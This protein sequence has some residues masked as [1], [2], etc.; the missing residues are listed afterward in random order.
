[1]EWPL[2]FA[3]SRRNPKTTPEPEANDVTSKRFPNVKII[4][5]CYCTARVMMRPIFCLPQI[6]NN[7]MIEAATAIGK[8]SSCT[9]LE[10]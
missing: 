2:F 8:M 3:N 7:G 1:M 9:K 5:Y 6:D 10:P 4:N